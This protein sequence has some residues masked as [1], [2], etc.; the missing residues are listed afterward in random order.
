MATWPLGLPQDVLS[1]TRKQ[2]PQ[3]IRTP[4]SAGLQKVRRRF[5]AAVDNWEL[6]LIMT[7]A[8]LKTLS[9]FFE[10][11]LDGG[12]D[13]FTWSAGGVFNEYSLSSGINVDDDVELRF[14]SKY[15]ETMILGDTDPALRKYSVKMEVEKLP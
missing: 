7:G 11:T 2:M 14:K 5:T 4:M 10:G 12:A 13:Q 9:T 3:T 1:A 6:R 15:T 8:E